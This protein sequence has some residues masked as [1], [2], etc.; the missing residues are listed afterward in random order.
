MTAFEIISS[1]PQRFRSEK[2]NG[3]LTTVSLQFIA[4][5]ALS[6]WVKV[7]ERGCELI[8]GHTDQADCTVRC[9]GENYAKMEM[10]ELNPQW[11]LVSGKVK[12][13]NVAV[14]L[15]FTKM[16]RRIKPESESKPMTE[17]KTIRPDL[18]GP[19]KGVRVLDLSRLLP[20][21][22]AT[23]WMAELGA[24]VIK[25]EDPDSPDP[26]RQFMP[27]VNGKSAF[28]EALN[29][30]KKSLGLNLRSAEGKAKFLSI[31]PTADV[32]VEGFRPGVM[33]SMGLDYEACKAVNPQLVYCSISGYGQTGPMASKAGHDINYM[34]MSGML[35][36]IPNGGMPSFQAADIAGG[37]YAAFG[38]VMAALI[39]QKTSNQGSYIDI[40]MTDAVKPMATLAHINHEANPGNGFELS[41][42]MPNYRTYLTKDNR[43]MALGALEPKFWERFCKKSQKLHLLNI[44]TFSTPEIAK[45]KDELEAFFLEK[46]KTECELWAEGEDFCFTP[47]MDFDEAKGSQISIPNNPFGIQ[48]INTNTGWAAPEIGEDNASF[49]WFNSKTTY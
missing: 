13:S 35:N 4:P 19:L 12:V 1:L 2:W 23:L 21:P 16:F 28:Y 46:T 42:Q 39:Q 6:Y 37:A 26:I 38:A 47:V 29:R 24:E 31:L 30:N 22:M 27:I 41:G 7:S 20:G 45:A 48:L 18:S 11:A 9:S 40:S 36:L 34:A 49:E 17:I 32:L 5:Q 33:K 8:E 15:E 3:T 25:I 44:Y 43:Y 14:M 10:G